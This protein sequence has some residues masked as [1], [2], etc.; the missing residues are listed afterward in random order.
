MRQSFSQLMKNALNGEIILEKLR[1]QMS[2][3]EIDLDKLFDE[4]MHQMKSLSS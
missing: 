2:K 3:E 1:D 4:W